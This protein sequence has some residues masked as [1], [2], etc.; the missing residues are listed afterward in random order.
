MII[1][2]FSRQG[3]DCVVKDRVY[4]L[5]D[6]GMSTAF[7]ILRATELGLVA[8]PVAGYDQEGV[9]QLLNIPQE[10]QVITLINVGKHSAVISPLLSEK[11]I[12]TEKERPPR[13]SFEEYA[14][15][16]RYSSS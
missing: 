16:N 4:N 10:Y 15:I 8:H 1:A 12:A 5:F 3:D 14:Y 7:L 13:K 6:A 2:V 11:Q 9:K